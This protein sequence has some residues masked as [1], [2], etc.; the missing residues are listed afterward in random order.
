MVVVSML[1]SMIADKRNILGQFLRYFVTGGLAF[2]VDFGVFSLALYCFEIHY[3]VSNLIGL[4]AG[5]VVNYLLSLGWVFCAE[6][7]KMEKHR[8]LEI[9][10]FVIISLVGMGL[11]EFLML[12]MVGYAELNE[13]FSK[14]VSAGVVLVYNF[15][16]R[17]FILFTKS[18]G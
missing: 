14:I 4:M 11:N 7:R 17:K 5:N 6:K 3:L 13:M 12:V 16:A 18:K 1:K 15:L 8:L 2:V 9:T 10:I